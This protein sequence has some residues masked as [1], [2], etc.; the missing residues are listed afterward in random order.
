MADKAGRITKFMGAFKGIPDEAQQE[1]D[2][3]RH[4]E[5]LWRGISDQEIA[6]EMLKAWQKIRNQTYEQMGILAMSDMSQITGEELKSRNRG[7]QNR[8]TG[9]SGYLAMFIPGFDP[10]ADIEED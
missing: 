7:Y 10:D 6:R 1:I 2:E 3:Q 8:L 5:K 9:I 4:R